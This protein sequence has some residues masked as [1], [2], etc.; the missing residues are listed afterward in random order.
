MAQHAPTVAPID[1]K[2]FLVIAYDAADS[3]AIRE[4]ELTGH[5]DYVE[6]RCEQYLVAGPMRDPESGS[7]IGSFFLVLAGSAEEAQSLVDGDP[8]FTSG[9]YGE[10]KIHGAV[11]AVGRFLGGVI[12][13][14]PEALRGRAS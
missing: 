6:K 14:D 3:A 7:I 8:Y 12:W 4:Q 13:D 11:P 2:A 1:G 5:L 10:V 9:L